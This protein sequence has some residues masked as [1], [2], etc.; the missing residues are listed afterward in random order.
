MNAYIGIDIAKKTYT[1]AVRMDGKVK[2]NEF[3]N[4]SDGHNK[5]LKWVKKITQNADRCFVIEATSTYHLDCALFLHQQGETVCVVNPRFIHNFR[6]ALGYENKTDITDAQVIAH[7]GEVKKPEYWQPPSKNIAILRDLVN[8]REELLKMR[9]QEKNRLCIP[10]VSEKRRKSVQRVIATLNEEINEIEEEIK[11]L[12]KNDPKIQKQVELLRT[13]KGIDRKIA[14]TL[15]AVI[16]DINLFANKRELISFLGV[17]PQNFHFGSS[18]HHSRLSKNGSAIA[19]KHLF[20]A[21]K[22]GSRWDP[23][24]RKYKEKLIARG[25]LWKTAICALMRKITGIIYAILKTQNPFSYEIYQKT[26]EKF[27]FSD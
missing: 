11:H 16:G 4:K 27:Q 22:I 18:V 12:V 20:I 26:Q 1:V 7:Y 24:F 15:V 25:K 19:R 3:E 5:M 14:I 6:K 10:L 23:I 8:R 17:N 9:Q 13:I 21:A 2:S